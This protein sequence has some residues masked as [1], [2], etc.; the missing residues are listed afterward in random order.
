MA[1]DVVLYWLNSYFIFLIISI[2][3]S[4]SAMSSAK[5]SGEIIY[6]A[7]NGSGDFNCDGIYDQVE[8]NKALA[9]VAENPQFKTVY[10]RAPVH[11][12]SRIVFLSEVI[13]FLKEIPLLWLSLKIK[14][15]GK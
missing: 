15:D 7:T 12:S 11:I 4:L 9:Y 14:Q 10:L 3:P 8:I 13:P 2:L 6:V 5:P 1:L